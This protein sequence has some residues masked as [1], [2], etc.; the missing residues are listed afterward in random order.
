MCVVGILRSNATAR[1]HICRN[2]RLA[3]TTEIRFTVAARMQV[4][5]VS[6]AR[7]R[8]SHTARNLQIFS[9]F[10][11][12]LQACVRLSRSHVKTCVAIRG[13]FYAFGCNDLSLFSS[14]SF[15]HHVQQGLFIY[16]HCWNIKHV[17][18]HG[19]TSDMQRPYMY[20]RR[21][22]FVLVQCIK[23]KRYEKSFFFNQFSLKMY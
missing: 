3:H 6:L 7:R 13:N 22:K 19:I 9:R 10:L 5:R 12:Y 23:S 18:M 17:L 20:K 21:L 2:I 4:S 15:P 8:E 14:F 11:F 16:V 1:H